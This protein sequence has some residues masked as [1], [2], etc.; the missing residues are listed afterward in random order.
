MTICETICEIFQ[1]TDWLRINSSLVLVLP[2]GVP[3]EA[4]LVELDDGLRALDVGLPRRH[5]V[6]L[7]RPLPLDEEHELAGGVGGA[8]DALRVE[9]AVEAARAVVVRLLL[10]V[11]HTGLALLPRRLLLGLWGAIQ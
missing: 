9:A 2:A 10:A 11:Q 6:G 4:L 5:Q 1:P 3:G 7:V 8:D